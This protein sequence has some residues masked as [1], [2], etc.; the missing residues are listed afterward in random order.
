MSAHEFLTEKFEALK[1]SYEG[2]INAL[3][4]FVGIALSIFLSFAGATY[5]LYLALHTEMSGMA[6]ELKSELAKTD[7]KIDTIMRENGNP[8]SAP[9]INEVVDTK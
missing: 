9:A 6:S 1:E 5:L 8:K 7:G 2:R 3:F 4:Y